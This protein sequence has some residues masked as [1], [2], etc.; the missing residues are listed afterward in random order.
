M[1]CPGIYYFEDPVSGVFVSTVKWHTWWLCRFAHHLHVSR[2]V[3]MM[4]IWVRW[5]L[6]DLHG[7]EALS[8]DG[9]GACRAIEWTEA[10]TGTRMNL[11]TP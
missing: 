5:G 10:K 11:L 9:H 4:F 2:A 3:S 8:G 7:G 1:V 6:W